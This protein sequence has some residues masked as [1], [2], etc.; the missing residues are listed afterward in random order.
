[1]PQSS[2]SLQ[3]VCH[4][5]TCEWVPFQDLGLG[6][7]LQ[8]FDAEKTG[9]SA[10]A[11]GYCLRDPVCNELIDFWGAF[12]GIKFTELYELIDFWKAFWGMNFTELYELIDFWRAFWGMNFTELYELIDFR[13]AFWGI[14]FT[15]L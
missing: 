9:R 12:W 8:S 3:P 15:E 13:G 7:H 2:L 11:S 1:M 10:P 5:A 4:G 14:N 6:R